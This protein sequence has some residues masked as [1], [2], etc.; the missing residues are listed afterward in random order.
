MMKFLLER[1]SSVFKIANCGDALVCLCT[2]RLA[3]ATRVPQRTM[4]EAQLPPPDLFASIGQNSVTV[5]QV[6]Q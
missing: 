3:V 5:N 2:A 6:S 4:S 1:Q